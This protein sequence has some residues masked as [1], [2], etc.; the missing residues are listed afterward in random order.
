VT[1]H[2]ELNKLVGRS[3]MLEGGEL[4]FR[5]SVTDARTVFDRTDVLVTPAAGN[6]SKWVSLVRVTLDPPAKDEE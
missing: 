4:S 1:I 6:G 2:S 3:G 5:V